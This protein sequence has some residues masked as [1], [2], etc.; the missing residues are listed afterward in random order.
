M[1]EKRDESRR[2]ILT[3]PYEIMLRI[4]SGGLQ[5]VYLDVPPDAGILD[6]HQDWARRSF[7]LMV[8]SNSFDSVPEGTEPP[9]RILSVEVRD[10]K[11]DA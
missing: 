8:Q 9:R 2:I 5:P 11:Q 1:D 4:L 3:I 7:S 6:V 10:V